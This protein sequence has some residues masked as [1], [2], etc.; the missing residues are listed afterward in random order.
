MLLTKKSKKISVPEIKVIQVPSTFQSRKS[1]QQR[2]TIFSK[3]NSRNSIKRALKTRN[4]STMN[5]F[6]PILKKRTSTLRNYDFS[7]EISMKEIYKDIEDEEN[8]PKLIKKFLEVPDC[9]ILKYGLKPSIEN[10]EFSFCR[11]CDP[12]LINPICIA[13]INTCHKSHKI[14]KKFIKGEIKC[15]CGERLHCISKT[16]DLTVNNNSCQL[17]EWYIISKINFFY[18][19]NDNSCLCMLCYNFCNKN[20]SEEK[21]IIKITE[22]DNIPECCCNNEEIHQEKKI[23]FEKIDE[24][25]CDMNSFEYFNLFHPSQIIN[26]IFLSQ[27]QFD[28]NYS[29]LIEVHNMFQSENFLESSKFNSFARLDFSNTICRLIFSHLLNFINWSKYNDITYFCGE[30]KNFFSFRMVKLVLS[31]MESMNHN[32]KSFWV[33]S[34]QYLKL[35]NKIYIGNICQSFAKFKLDDLENF[36]SCLRWSLSNLN[37]KNFSESQEIINHLISFLTK[38]NITGFSNIEAFGTIEIIIAIF[39]KMVKYNLVSSSDMIKI[40]QEIDKNLLEAKNLRKVLRKNEQTY[41]N[42]MSNERRMSIKKK[43]KLIT[44]RE[45]K[46]YYI[47]IKLLYNLNLCFNDKL[48]HKIIINNNNNSYPNLESINAN[49]VVFS[50]VKSELG[51]ALI[52]L[53]IRVLYTLQAEHFEFFREDKYKKIMKYGMKILNCFLLPN[54]SYMLSII[55]SIKNVEYY[56]KINLIEVTTD[57]EY[58]DIISRK[59]ELETAY[60]KFF[61]FEYDFTN[62]INDVKISLNK[63]LELALFEENTTEDKKEVTLEEK[64]LLCILKSKYYFSLTKFFR[65][66]DV[67]QSQMEKLPKGLEKKKLSE[68]Y[69]EEL[70][71]LIKRIFTFFRA[72][73]HESSDNSLILMSFYIFKDLCKAPVQYGLLNF[74]MFYTACVNIFNNFSVIGSNFY[75]INNLFEYLEILRTSSYEKINECLYIFMEIFEMFVLNMKS[76]DLEDN[77]KE[78]RELVVNINNEYKIFKTFFD[79]KANLKEDPKFDKCLLSYIKLINNVFDFTDEENKSDSTN[80]IY[81]EKVIYAIKYYNLNLDMRTEFLKYIRK[82]NIDLSYNK[83]SNKIYTNSIISIEDNL[84]LLK[85]NP[86][87]TNF[88]YP[89]RLLSYFKDFVNLSART[90]YHQQMGKSFSESDPSSDINTNLYSL[91]INSKPINN[92]PKKYKPMSINMQVNE[93]K[94]E[95]ENENE[96]EKEKENEKE[97]EKEMEKED[98]KEPNEEKKEGKSEEESES[99]EEEEKENGEMDNDKD[100]YSSESSTTKKVLKP[101]FDNETY[102]VLLNELINLK[103]II[104]NVKVYEE[105]QM[106]SLRNYFE[107]GLLIPIIYFLKRA[108]VFA[109]CF[110]GKEMLKIYELI[111]ESCNLRLYIAEYKNNFWAEDNDIG[112]VDDEYK[113]DYNFAN[114]NDSQ[115]L[116]YV[117]EK[118]NFCKVYNNKSY[119]INGD[120]CVN[121][122][123][124]EITE[125]ALHTLQKRKSLCFDFTSLY[126]IFEKNLLSLLKDRKENNYGDF[127]NEEEK[128]ISL[129]S[130]EKEESLLFPSYKALNEKQKKIIRLY[131][132]YNLCKKYYSTNENNSS[133]FSILPELCLEYET[134]FRTLLITFLVNNGIKNEMFENKLNLAFPLL[135]KLLY[136]QTSETQATLINLI[137]G[138]DTDTSDLGFMNEFSQYLFKKVILLFIELFNPP[139]KL[140]DINYVYSFLLIKIFKFLCEEHNNFFQCRLIKTLTY[141][142]YEEIPMYYKEVSLEDNEDNMKNNIKIGVIESRY[143]YIEIRKSKSQSV[144]FFDFFLHV[145]LKIMLISEWQKLDSIEESKRQQNTYLYDIFAAI[146]EMLNEIIQGSRPE[147][148]N[149]LGNSIL[150]SETN[151]LE[152]YLL[153]ENLSNNRAGIEYR[154]IEKVDSFQYFVKT[155]TEFIFSDRNT[156]EL[157]YKIKNDLMQFFITI[158]EEKNCNE[159]IQKFIIKYLNINRV[160]STISSILKNYYVMELPKEENNKFR[161]NNYPTKTDADDSLIVNYAKNLFT[162]GEFNRFNTL[163]MD[164]SAKGETDGKKM[165]MNN[166]YFRAYVLEKNKFIFNEKLLD[167]YRDCYFYGELNQSNE[168]Q[169]S[170]VF[171]KYIKLIAVLNKSDEAKNLIEQAEIMTEE[172]ARR[173][174]GNSYNGENKNNKKSNQNHLF[175]DLILKKKYN[176]LINKKSKHLDNSKLNESEMM[177]MNINKENRNKLI[178]KEKALNSIKTLY[179]RNKE[180]KFNSLINENINEIAKDA[181]EHYYIIKFF[182]SITKTIEVRTEEAINQTVIFTKPPE[183][184]Y[185]SNGTKSEFEREA[186]RDS[187]TSKKNDLVTHV[188]YFQ[189]EINYYQNKQSA[190]A[191]WISKIDFLYV[192]IGCYI[193]FL[194]FNLLLLF[195]LKGDTNITME[196]TADVETRRQN[197]E[198]IKSLIHSSLLKYANIYNYICYIGVGINGFFI[199]VWTYFRLPLYYQVDRLKYMKIHNIT[200]E[201]QLTFFQR[202]YIVLVMTIY[203]RGYIIT[204]IFEFIFSLIGAI[205]KRGEIIYAFLLLPII[206]LNKLVENIIVSIKLFYGEVSLTFFFMAI[207]I[208]IFSNFAFFFFNHD[209]EK[210]IEYKEDNLCKTLVFCFLNAMDSGLRARGGIG[211]SG[212]RISFRLNRSHYLKRI[213][214][215]DFFFI[216]IVITAIDLVF[217]IIIRAFANLRDVEQKHENDRKNHCF[218]CHVNKNSLEKNRQNFEEHRTRI[219]NLWNYVDY[220]ITLKF[221]DVHDLNAINSYAAEKLFNKDISWLP[222]YKDLETK[223]KNGE[224]NEFE[225]E[226]KVEDENVNKYFVKTF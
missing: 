151:D 2:I 138:N 196:E 128:G 23:F 157:L 45:L 4:T 101:V 91:Y 58:Q 148:L 106:E 190:L 17:G 108:F 177:N 124:N 175:T 68:E 52:K 134:N 1:N 20:K 179:L 29:D 12:N 211:D 122:S 107:N 137:G 214:M 197:R 162:M 123:L 142:Y 201:E 110:S 80:I 112:Y 60:H 14:K 90:E 163:P 82:I 131:M 99:N 26:M 149:H 183:M 147:F 22:D 136:L 144:K 41:L 104:G 89:T 221:S 172:S 223:G 88:R 57:D 159:E 150:K 140:F 72:F 130:I 192:Q 186:D 143:N 59:K 164:K 208:Y 115:V 92:Q 226:L 8:S 193:Y 132:I 200:K 129:K 77:M 220:M 73:I 27:T 39:R 53:T 121:H 178:E 96:E 50:F 38:I 216:L 74:E 40:V 100:D 120:F 167:Y 70:N 5:N 156:L 102:D 116:N 185:L 61:N 28:Q 49:S 34:A 35:F 118:E 71:N 127:F 135:Y 97:N 114:E 166:G 98:K 213:I 42:K 6:F 30:A 199:L 111:I 105:D 174:F 62:V 75:Y 7:E 146:L 109:H 55:Q 210:E 225:E 217:G 24:I 10:V 165:L 187:E 18:K 25:A 95:A 94:S 32:E 181:I 126:N 169:L 189:K 21:D 65:I 15:I 43:I 203:D 215:D 84:V 51:R 212:K 78:I 224:N 171:Y 173:K 13:C 206:N 16:P 64:R 222:T 76:L 139:D 145:I 11:T 219:H 33:L 119:F 155:V 198:Q 47:I 125:K 141:D 113:V 19:T 204:L 54:D 81:P 133:L 48:V 63:V 188:T 69:E 79:N 3:S 202:T 207:I 87:I 46:I 218:I 153:G 36:S 66:L 170:N 117:I 93:E 184:I 56:E 182:E 209:Y 168:F 154:V 86:L 194:I 161:K 191:Q 103:D 85:T 83:N 176:S 160:F 9:S 44:E 152:Q 180:M 37:S 31:I 195:T 205:L 158:L 67:Y